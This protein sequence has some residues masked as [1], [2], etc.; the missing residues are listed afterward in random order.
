MLHPPESVGA[1]SPNQQWTAAASVYAYFPPGTGNFLQPTL[2]ADHDWLHLEARYNYE[3][4]DTGSVWFGYNLSGGRQLE[5]TFSPMLG[6]VFG[7]LSG[8]AP[9]YSGSLS[10]QTLE[11]YSEGEYVID[12][13]NTSASY[14]YNW[15]ELSLGLFDRLRI[16]VVVQHTHVYKSER[17]IQR[18]VLAGL[19]YQ[20]V[21]LTGYLLNPD[22]A[23]TVVIALSVNW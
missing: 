14:F 19:S 13:A 16:G 12:T 4:L 2:S 17:E 6:A 5:W 1:S 22:H 8:I 7:E 23:P 15:S 9:G 21:D 10:W 3:E 11:L 18:G 20:R